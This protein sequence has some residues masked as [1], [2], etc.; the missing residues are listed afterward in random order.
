MARAIPL[1]DD[2]SGEDL[3]RLARSSGHGRQVRRLLSLSMIYDGSS[4]RE[5]AAHAEVD[6]QTLRDWVLRFNAEGPEGLID[7]KSTGPHR[8]L[9]VEQRA[10]L[11]TV[12][13]DGPTPYIDDVVRWRLSDLVSWIQRE[14]GVSM[15]ETT[16]GRNLREMGYRK[17]SARPRHHAQDAEAMETF[18]KNSPPEWR[19]S[20]PASPPEQP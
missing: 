5:A 2:Y 1:R 11:A 18:K 19:R 12:I 20:D 15:D 13:D 8:R 17:L 16:L 3:R 9:T 14:F 7:A 4:R 6:L 10:L